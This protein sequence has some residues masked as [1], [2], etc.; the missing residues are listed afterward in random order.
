MTPDYLFE[1]FEGKVITILTNDGSY[2]KGVLN[3]DK[4]NTHYIVIDEVCRY[5]MKSELPDSLRI[6]SSEIYGIGLIE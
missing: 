3:K 5:T 6:R 4:S 1:G 2:L